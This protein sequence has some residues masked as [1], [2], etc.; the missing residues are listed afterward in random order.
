MATDKKKSIEF[1]R[2]A[3]PNGNGISQP[4]DVINLQGQYQSLN[5][6]NGSSYSR[7]KSHLQ[8]KY[9]LIKVYEKGTIDTKIATG[10][11]AGVGLGKLKTIQLNG[12]KI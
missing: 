4:V 5:V 8:E 7:K 1:I 2:L 9:Y 10:D 6:S 3:N 12:E 11:N